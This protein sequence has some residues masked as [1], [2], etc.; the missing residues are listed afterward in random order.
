MEIKI[1]ACL[2]S[3]KVS[4]FRSREENLLLGWVVSGEGRKIISYCLR[5]YLYVQHMVF[6]MGFGAYFLASLLQISNS[7]PTL[8]GS[9][10]DDL[11][12]GAHRPRCPKN[13]IRS[14]SILRLCIWLC[15]CHPTVYFF[16]E[17]INE[18]RKAQARSKNNHSG[19]A[20]KEISGIPGRTAQKG[21]YPTLQRN[22]QKLR[23]KYQG[24]RKSSFSFFS[25]I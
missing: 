8:T 22:K 21:L 23:A 19:D 16:Q 7:I 18:S 4:K 10:S 1:L 3:L 2:G 13:Y 17:T 14:S 12:R 15:L 25:D 5:N 9:V 24:E 11:Q 6:I 20:G